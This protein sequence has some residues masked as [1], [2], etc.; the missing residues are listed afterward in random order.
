VACFAVM[1]HFVRDTLAK[2]K[3]EK[4]EAAIYSH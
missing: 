1:A 4:E 2:S 3:P